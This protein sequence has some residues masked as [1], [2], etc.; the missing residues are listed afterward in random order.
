[1]GVFQRESQIAHCIL[2]SRMQ[3]HVPKQHVCTTIWKKK[4]IEQKLVVLINYTL[5]KSTIIVKEKNQHWCHWQYQCAVRSRAHHQAT[6]DANI[7]NKGY[8]QNANKP[9]GVR[10]WHHI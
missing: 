7:P 2:S 3:Q 10:H 5:Y 4:I 8:P 9:D 6:N 1:M